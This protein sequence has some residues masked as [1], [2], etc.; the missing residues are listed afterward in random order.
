MI[1]IV[2]NIVL[3]TSNI[4]YIINFNVILKPTQIIK[5]TKQIFVGI[6]YFADSKKEG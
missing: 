4:I 2:I 3:K 6:K 5:I 1:V